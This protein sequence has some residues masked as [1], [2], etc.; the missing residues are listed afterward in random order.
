MNNQVSLDYE[1]EDLLSEPL[2]KEQQ[3]QE[4]DNGTLP[5]EDTSGSEDENQ[6]VLLSKN[7]KIILW[8]TWIVFSGRSIWNQNVLA[9]LCF[10]LKDGDPKAVGFLTAAMGL[11]QMIVSFPTG[12]V[13]DRYRRDSLLRFASILGVG[14]ATITIIVLWHPHGEGPRYM[15]LLFAL[16]VWGMFWGV[17]NTCISALYADSVPNGQRSSYF[18]KRNVLT[19]LGNLT[20]PLVALAMF[21]LLGNEWTIHECSVVMGLGQIICIPAMVLLCCLDDDDTVPENRLSNLASDVEESLLDES[22]IESSVQHEDETYD[23]TSIQSFFGCCKASRIIP[24]MVA[25]ADIMAGLASG[26]SIRYFSIFLYDNLALSPVNV[27]IIYVVIPLL[28]ATLMKCAQ[29]LAKLFG[30]CFIA[31]TF[32]WIGISLMVAMILMA[33]RYSEDQDS[34]PSGSSLLVKAISTVLVLRTAFMNS[35]R[36][37]TNSVLMDHV[38]KEERAKWSALESFNMFSWSGSAA[39]GGFLVQYDGILFNFWI[40]AGLQFLA[41]FPLLILSFNVAPSNINRDPQTAFHIRRQD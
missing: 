12:W 15:W 6:E 19:T 35:T 31:V 37:L 26:M 32:K 1:I 33:N 3:E 22:P 8:Y 7:V 25:S 13:A 11:S 18:T 14:A 16:C 20:G 10:L 21:L 23:A 36:A 5:C 30:R 41:T 29:I 17:T 39:L 4:D 24:T 40:T 27:Q 2:L 38:P 34:H 9:T 28:Q